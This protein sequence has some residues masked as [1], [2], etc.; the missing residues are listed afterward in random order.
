MIF[1]YSFFLVVYVLYDLFYNIV[2]YVGLIC[3]VCGL[4]K[5]TPYTNILGTQEDAYDW[6]LMVVR[7]REKH[8]GVFVIYFKIRILWIFSCYFE[9]FNTFENAVMSYLPLGTL[10]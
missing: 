2:P 6:W 10:G 3:M 9:L 8:Y 4:W 1:D 7:E 5:L